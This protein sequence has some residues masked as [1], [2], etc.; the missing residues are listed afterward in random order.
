MKTA[1]FILITFAFLSAS[2]LSLDGNFNSSLR[3]G[4]YDSL[5]VLRQASRIDLL[6]AGDISEQA[7]FTLR[8][9]VSKLHDE[10]VFAIDDLGSLLSFENTELAVREA[11][12]AMFGIF[13]GIADLRI[14]RLRVNWGAG[15]AI[16]PAD[17]LNPFDLRDKWTYEERLGADG[18]LLDIYTG[19]FKTSFFFT[20]YFQPDLLPGINSSMMKGIPQSADFTT[21]INMPGKSIYER[22]TAAFREKADIGG[23]SF[24]MQYA[25]TRDCMPW[26]SGVSI[27]QGALPIFIYVNAELFYPRMHIAAASARGSIRGAGVWAEGALFIP[28][29]NSYIIDMTGAGGSSKDAS[30]IEGKMYAKCIAGM[31]Y[32]FENGYYLNVQYLHGFPGE[33]G[34]ENI[35][36]FMTISLRMPLFDGKVEF[37]PLDLS[38]GIQDEGSIYNRFSAVFMPSAVFKPSGG[39]ALE[40]KYLE[41]MGSDESILSNIADEEGAEL[42]LKVYF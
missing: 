32:L 8:A 27:T 5:S 25:Y 13:G 2:G 20:P 30:N 31:D 4:V 11:E 37:N 14:G 15:D 39:V 17:I 19:A 3:L 6:A 24:S 18:M 1:L 40:V 42:R 35:N 23:W 26:T 34:E 22:F 36:E 16:S 21:E 7:K 28:E 12:A 29:E 38:I 41:Y 10:H 33:A 9:S